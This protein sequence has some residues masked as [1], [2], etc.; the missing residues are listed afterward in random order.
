MLLG[1]HHFQVDYMQASR[2]PRARSASK[3]ELECRENRAVRPCS[4]CGLARSSYF[5]SNS[6]TSCLKS[7]RSRSVSMSMLLSV[8]CS[9]DMYC[10][11][12]RLVRRRGRPARLRRVRGKRR[13]QARIEGGHIRDGIWL[14]RLLSGRLGQVRI[15]RLIRHWTISQTEGGIYQ[16]QPSTRFRAQ[17][18]EI[19]L[20]K[21]R[22]AGKSGT[23]IDFSF[24]RSAWERTSGRSASRTLQSVARSA[25]SSRA[26]ERQGV[27]SHAER[28][29]EG[30]LPGGGAFRSIPTQGSLKVNFPFS[31]TF[32]TPSLPY[33]RGTAPGAGVPLP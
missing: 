29:N 15:V 2:P 12:D 1:C 4:R 31:A 6:A 30:K 16:V 3:D 26:A 24:P 7:A 5:F 32:A 13:R 22:Q 14:L 11:A 23:A 25:S 19:I 10:G 18:S 28:G 17:K 9:G 21:G 20:K 8:A 27:R 33:P